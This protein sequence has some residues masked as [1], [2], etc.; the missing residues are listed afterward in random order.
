MMA[1]LS[2]V[3]YLIGGLICISLIIS[4]VEHF[5]MS[6][7]ATCILSLKKCLFGSSSHFLIELFEIL[8]LSCMSCLYMLEINPLS[9][10]SFTN[11][12]SHSVGFQTVQMLWTLIRSH[13]FIFAFVSFTLGGASKKILL[14]VM[15][16][17]VLPLF[18]L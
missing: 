4:N 17:S 16:K 9:V 8:I 3:R 15:S 7:L 18:S 5:F 1:N 11:I 2:S 12:F 13:L 6:L 10:A 14:H